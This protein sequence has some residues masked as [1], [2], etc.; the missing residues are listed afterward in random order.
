MVLIM[1]HGSHKQPLDFSAFEISFSYSWYTGPVRFSRSGWTGVTCP[2]LQL[3]CRFSGQVAVL[4]L[5]QWY[6]CVRTTQSLEGH[7]ET[8]VHRSI[9][10]WGGGGEQV[11]MQSNCSSTSQNSTLV[12]DGNRPADSASSTQL[13][14]WRVLPMGTQCESLPLTNWPL[15][16]GPE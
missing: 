15:N 8:R 4:A 5:S 7:V 14:Y 16:H 9:M 12:H 13:I 10:G 6:H 1:G 2:S 11:H 3:R